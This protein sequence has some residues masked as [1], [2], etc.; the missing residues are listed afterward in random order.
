M[1]SSA[2]PYAWKERGDLAKAEA[3]IA[4]GKSRVSEQILLIN[5]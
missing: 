3:D 2:T 1:I 4:A 5:D